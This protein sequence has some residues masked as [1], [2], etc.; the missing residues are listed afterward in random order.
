MVTNPI[1]PAIDP[2]CG[3][4]VYR[5]IL[6]QAWIDPDDPNKMKAEAFMRRRPKLLNNGEIDDPR[7]IDGL[8]VFDSY[9]MDEQA[10]I[11]TCNRCYGVAT[12]HVGTLLDQGLTVIRDPQ[13]FTK[14]L[15][16]NIPFEN[17]ANAD[18]ERLMESIAETARIKKR[19][20]HRKSN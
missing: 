18:E 7:D 17:P 14:I 4:I 6:K 1:D 11:E 19:G 20:K 12:L 5:L 15:I 9:R 10:C 2:P 8:S 13:D 3:T 16:T